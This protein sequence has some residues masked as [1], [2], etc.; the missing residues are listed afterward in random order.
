MFRSPVNK[1]HQ[2]RLEKMEKQESQVIKEPMVRSQLAAEDPAVLLEN[3]DRKE[4]GATQVKM[5]LW[6]KLVRKDHL[7]LLDSKV[8]LDR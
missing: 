5:A 1:A 8:P 3:K 2:E 6:A 4:T 7:D